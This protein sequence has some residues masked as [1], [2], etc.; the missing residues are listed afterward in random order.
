ML[1]SFADYVIA[2]AAQ[3]GAMDGG[4]VNLIT[5]LGSSA[6]AIFVVVYFLAYL[7]SQ[8]ERTAAREKARDEQWSTTVKQM[9]DHLEAVTADKGVVL[10]ENAVAMHKFEDAVNRLSAIVDQLARKAVP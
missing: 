9:F 3:P 4:L 5:S 2:Q 6:A 10:R 8:D 7:K 1:A